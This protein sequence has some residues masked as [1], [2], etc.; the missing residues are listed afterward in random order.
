MTSANYASKENVES[1]ARYREKLAYDVDLGLDMVLDL[2]F[3][4][5]NEGE[6]GFVGLALVTAGGII[7]GTVVH[8]NAFAA[9]QIASMEQANETMA[10]F[11]KIAEEKRKQLT[12]EFTELQESEPSA[13]RGYVH[14]K[15]ATVTNGGS[16]MQLENLKVSL[17]NVIGWSLGNRTVMS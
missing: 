14:F 17:K 3:G 15:T 11:L 1:R 6:D 10:S 9:S 13:L 12:K 4:F 8:P 5:K 2:V 16:S 7:T